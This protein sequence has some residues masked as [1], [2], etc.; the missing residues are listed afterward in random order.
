MWVYLTLAIQKQQEEFLPGYR[1]YHSFLQGCEQ[2]KLKSQVQ[3]VGGLEGNRPSGGKVQ[4]LLL[5]SKYEQFVWWQ[6]SNRGETKNMISAWIS[7]TLTEFLESLWPTS[8]H[9][10]LY[11]Y[12]PVHGDEYS[13]GNFLPLCFC[14]SLCS[15]LFVSINDTSKTCFSNW[16]RMLNSYM[17]PCFH[18]W[19]GCDNSLSWCPTALYLYFCYSSWQSNCGSSWRHRA[20]FIMVGT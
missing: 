8:S 18:P 3:K 5:T 4:I 6:L 2:L 19:F 16:V 15:N 9:I 17:K 1:Y 20:W 14:F 11:P 13:S 12:L 10:L 7:T